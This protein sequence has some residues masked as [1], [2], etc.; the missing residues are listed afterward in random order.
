MHRTQFNV[1]KHLKLIGVKLL[2]TN[3][4]SNENVYL[5]EA[6]LLFGFFIFK[7]NQ[8]QLLL[9]KIMKLFQGFGK[10]AYLLNNTFEYCSKIC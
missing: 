8:L 2:G 6:Y 7:S 1:Y 4:L 3:N 9:S 5:P 10:L